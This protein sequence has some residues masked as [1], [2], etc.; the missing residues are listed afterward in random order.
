MPSTNLKALAN[1]SRKKKRTLF[2]Q[3]PIYLLLKLP[4]KLKLSKLSSSP[5]IQLKSNMVLIHSSGTY[6][7]LGYIHSTEA[8]QKAFQD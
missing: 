6:Q 8:L 7:V 5:P 3:V 1:P 4:Q 2:F